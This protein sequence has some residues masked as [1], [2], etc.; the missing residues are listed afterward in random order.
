MC[1][2]ILF[3]EEKIRE[4]KKKYVWRSVYMLDKIENA[5]EGVFNALKTAPLRSP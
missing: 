1:F 4:E 5:E 2:S 3:I